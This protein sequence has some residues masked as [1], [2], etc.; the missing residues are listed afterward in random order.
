MDRNRTAVLMLLAAA[1]FW[2][3]SGVMIKWVDLSPLAISG[4]RSLIAG[5]AILALCRNSIVISWD[6][7]TLAAAACMGLFSTCFVGATKLGTAANAIVLQ[8]SASAYVAVLAPRML[9][10]P[11]QRRDWL[12]LAFVVTGIGLFFF[13]KLSLGGI[14][15]ILLG[16][17]GSVF[18]AG[19][20]IFL[21][22]TR[23]QST[24]WPLALG[25]FMAAGLCLPFMFSQVPTLG[26]SA[27]LLGLGV[28]SIGLGYAVY[29]VAIRHVT[30]LEAVLICSVEPLINPLWVFLG[31]GEVPGPAAL[32]GGSLVLAAVTARGIFSA[33]G[34]RK[35]PGSSVKPQPDL[36]G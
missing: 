17:L 6:R 9:G 11:T 18:W 34:D 4:W 28:V 35:L 2:S 23:N 21:R 31:T 24:A 3:T 12:F 27:G 16:I 30:A 7:N 13:D 32:A 26:D 8:Y 20:V 22:K 10:E 19:L 5:V 29:S 36:T 15:G 33:V 25:S 1:F 14:Y